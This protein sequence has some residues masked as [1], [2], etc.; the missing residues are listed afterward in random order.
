VKNDT[1]RTKIIN[2]IYLMQS[3]SCENIISYKECYEYENKI[4]IVMECMDETLTELCLD[5]GGRIDESIMAYILKSMLNG[6]VFLHDTHRL[7]RDIK[8]DNILLSVNGG[9]KLGDFGF[10]A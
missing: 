3:A 8:S 10:A 7:H 9:L 6:L 5:M 4:W 1:Q 2:E